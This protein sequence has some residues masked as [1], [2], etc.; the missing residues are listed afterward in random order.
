[1][2]VGHLQHLQELCKVQWE[3]EAEAPSWD[4]HDVKTLARQYARQIEYNFFFGGPA[5]ANAVKNA[6]TCC[7]KEAGSPG[8]MYPARRLKI[9]QARQQKEIKGQRRSRS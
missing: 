6:V 1:M 2:G 4:E 3:G 5:L 8:L 9:K 7:R